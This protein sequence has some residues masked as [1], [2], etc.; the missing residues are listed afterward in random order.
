[1]IVGDNLSGTL[2]ASTS[3]SWLIIVGD[4]LSGT[5]GASISSSW[6]VSTSGS[7]IVSTLFSNFASFKIALRVGSPDCK[8]G[9][10]LAG[11]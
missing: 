11:G 7:G 5:L 8:E 10:V 6:L 9:T 3:S 1:M 4:D 2:R